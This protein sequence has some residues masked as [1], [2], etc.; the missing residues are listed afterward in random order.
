MCPRKTLGFGHSILRMWHF[1]FYITLAAAF[2]EREKEEKK[3]NENDKYDHIH[4]IYGTL[5]FS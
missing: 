2:K 4:Q 3:E 1:I 5:N